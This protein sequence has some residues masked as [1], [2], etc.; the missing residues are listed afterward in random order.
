MM[1]F[2]NADFEL[3][4]YSFMVGRKLSGKALVIRAWS[5]RA[6]RDTVRPLLLKRPLRGL[7]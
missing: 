6:F 7:A 5:P 3:I 2:I 4:S 1:S